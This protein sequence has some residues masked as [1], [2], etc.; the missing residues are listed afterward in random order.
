ME[1]YKGIWKDTREYKEIRGNL[2]NISADENVNNGS[3]STT[4][5][6]DTWYEPLFTFPANRN[7]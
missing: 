5:V 1:R 7:T 3:A 4:F 2:S 6:G